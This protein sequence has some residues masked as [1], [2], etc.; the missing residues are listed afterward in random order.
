M[1]T[2]MMKSLFAGA[3]AFALIAGAAVAQQSYDSTTSRTTTVTTPVQVMPAVP[4]QTSTT[5]IER[6]YGP[7][8]VAPPPPVSTY[9]EEHVRTEDGQTVEKSMKTETASPLGSRTTTYSQTTTKGD[10]D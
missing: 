5:T 1:E 4:A 7:V 6:S 8:A 2:K 10:N 9:H 3:A